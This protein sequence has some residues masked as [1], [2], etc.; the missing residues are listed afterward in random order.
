MNGA[1]MRSIQARLRVT[2]VVYLMA[3]LA[4]AVMGLHA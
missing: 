3:L 1:G 2:A 4:F